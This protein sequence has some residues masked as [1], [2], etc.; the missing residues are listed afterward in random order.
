MNNED[1]GESLPTWTMTALPS[2]RPFGEWRGSHL[3]AEADPNSLDALDSDARKAANSS[4][5]SL[6]AVIGRTTV[7]T[8]RSRMLPRLPC[9]PLDLLKRVGPLRPSSVRILFRLANFVLL[10]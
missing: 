3:R 8:A 9:L 5:R 10:F 4:E 7:N 2:A 6:G 1:A